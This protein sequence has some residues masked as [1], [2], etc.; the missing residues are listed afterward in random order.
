MT[1][2]PH[3][4][5]LHDAHTGDWVIIAPK[6]A[7]RPIAK[8]KKAKVDDR[9][10]IQNLKSEK[11]L[12]VYGKGVNRIAVVENKYPVFQPDIDIRGHQE[13][14]VEGTATGAFVDFSLRQMEQV[15]QAYVARATAV[16]TRPDLQSVIIFKNEGFEAGASQ[17]HA[18]SQL[19]GLSFVP[20]RWK[21]RATKISRHARAMRDVTPERTIFEDV[22]VIAFAHPSAR[23]PYEVR[24]LPRREVDNI[25][26]LT[27]TEVRSLAKA[28]FTL[29]KL[30]KQR[31]LA[32]NFFF[33]DVFDDRHES[34]ELHFVPRGVN[35]W[36]G[37]ELDAG[38]AINPISAEMAA[39]AYRDAAKKK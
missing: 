20:A 2:A 21:D 9:F 4:E 33:H 11:I 15:F 37:F 24:V 8:D 29:L 14:L 13:I 18:H 3:S 19:Y 27:E 39:Q 34:F 38:I 26:L 31:K 12:A 36:G 7:H 28:V 16:S 22:S 10:S 25:T 17:I 6:R 23:F 30:V 35:V 32:F 5:L 1:E